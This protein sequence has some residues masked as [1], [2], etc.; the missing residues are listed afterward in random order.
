MQ[1]SLIRNELFKFLRKILLVLYFF[2]IIMLVGLFGTWEKER[3]RRESLKE[4]HCL[5]RVRKEQKKIIKRTR[6]FSSC[7][8]RLLL[9]TVIIFSHLPSLSRRNTEEKERKFIFAV[10][11]GGETGGPKKFCSF[12]YHRKI[13]TV[14]NYPPKK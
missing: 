5:V 8:S 4:F 2:T 10:F 13:L 1:N 6:I 7:F 14:R 3:K 11:F 9:N 12:T